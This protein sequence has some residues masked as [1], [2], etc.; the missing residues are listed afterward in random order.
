MPGN[1][2]LRRYL[3]L[4]ISQTSLLEASMGLTLHG[5]GA[6]LT[7]K[8]TLGADL[9]RLLRQAQVYWGGAETVVLLKNKQST[10]GGKVQL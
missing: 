6:I 9:F 2:S 4:D 7:K 3:P 10:H 8:I 1:L 5:D